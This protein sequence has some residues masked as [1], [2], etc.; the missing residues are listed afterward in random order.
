MNIYKAL[1]EIT[2]YIEDNL[3]NRIDYDVLASFLGVNSYT[4][5]R[6]FSLMI[7]TTISD[8]I[9]KRRLSKAALDLYNNPDLKVI[10]VAIKYQYN[11]ATAFSRAFRSFHGIKPSKVDLTKLRNFP[12][13]VFDEKDMAVKEVEYEIIEL[14]S[15]E[16]YGLKMKTNNDKIA[17][18]AP[19]FYQKVS[20]K[21]LNKYGNIDYGMVTYDE[22]RENC[23]YYYVLY[24]QK[25]KEF[26][27]VILPKSRWLSFR[28]PS[29]NAIDIH[30]ASQDF[31]LSFLPSCN[32]NL[33][34][35]PE[36]EYY[37]DGVTDFLVAID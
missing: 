15:L 19:Y 31:Y 7:G 37:H 36:L 33:K 24:K 5:Q 21:Y 34:P 9:R 28:I 22:E 3:E 14:D 2:S 20:N 17:K 13:I 10:D 32:Y 25:I 6:L 27:K 12:R 18:D 30:N 11:N 35:I 29:Q 8:Y 4:M 26:E 1:N 23:Q 16:L